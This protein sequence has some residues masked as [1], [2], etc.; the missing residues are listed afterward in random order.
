LG[1]SATIYRF[2]VELSDIDRS[3]YETLDLRVAKH[4]SEDEERMVVRVLARAI[5]HEEGLE[6]GRGLSNAEDAGLW[7]HS[8][9]GQVATWIDVGAPGAERLHRA[10]KQSERL[11]VFT[12]KPEALL[13]KEWRTRKI[14][15]AAE[16]LVYRLPSELVGRLAESVGRKASWFITIQDGVMGVTSGDMSLEGSV[17]VITLAELVSAK[18]ES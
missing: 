11:L 9:T 18:P 8:M 14:H 13:R 16:I 15:K 3:V 12:H 4:P 2:Q 1:T 5:A 6:F 17:E 10:S 7:T